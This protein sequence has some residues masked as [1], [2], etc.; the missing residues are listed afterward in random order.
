[1][2]GAIRILSVKGI[3]IFVHWTFLLLIGWV[4]LVNARWGVNIEPMFWTVLFIL[5]VFA[6]VIL[7]E[8]GHALT[9]A[10][11]GIKAK[12]IVLL[13]IGG[14]ASIEKFPDNPRQE[15]IISLAGPMV[16]LGIAIALWLFFSPDTPFW[17]VPQDPSITHGHDFVYNLRIV[18][19]GLAMFN[20]IPAFPMDGGRILRALLGFKLNYIKA[21]S[22]A[23]N[24][25]RV[26][27][28]I[29]I[30]LGIVMVN[31]FLPLIGLFI[32]FSASTEEY[33]LRLRSLVKG[34]KLGEVLM[35]DY[36]SLQANITVR[37][38]AT[39]LENNHHKYFVLMEGE[40]PIGTI[41][42]LE[43]VKALAEM[44]YNDAL[45]NLVQEKLESLEANKDVDKVLEKLADNDERIFPVMQYGHM[46]GVV[47][48]NHIVEYLLLHRTDSP[49]FPRIK[50]LIGLLH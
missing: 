13:P 12:N 27:A 41:N 6:C 17:S 4:I 24:I 26:V 2:R 38:A 18:N 35:Y 22:I 31:L 32:I 37:E 47:N 28:V 39:V 7:H 21:T 29:F 49:E 10:H 36:N 14:I 33:Y 50:S 16:N 3:S 25:G 20:L 9:A 19:V 40:K 48:F 15:L 42:R 30:G 46:R 1:M 5:A 45:K 8:L 44:R 23:A 11:F 34:I 43:I